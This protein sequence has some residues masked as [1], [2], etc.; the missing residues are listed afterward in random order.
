MLHL[1][2]VT[3]LVRDARSIDTGAHRKGILPRRDAMLPND[4]KTGDEAERY[5]RRQ[6]PPPIDILV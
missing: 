5:L 3:A 6:K 1:R 4:D 2:T